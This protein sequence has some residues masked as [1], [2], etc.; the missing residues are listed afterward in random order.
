[1]TM[2]VNMEVQKKDFTLHSRQSLVHEFFF[3]MRQN[4]VF[5]WVQKRP[6][7]KYFAHAIDSRFLHHLQCT[8]YEFETLLQSVDLC[9]FHS[10]WYEVFFFEIFKS[11]NLCISRFVLSTLFLSMFLSEGFKKLRRLIEELLTKNRHEY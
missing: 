1:M 2:T 7:K 5:L 4:L 9:L 3:V 8:L 10:P 11:Y 6:S